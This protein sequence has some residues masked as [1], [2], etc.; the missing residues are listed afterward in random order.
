MSRVLVIPDLGKFEIFENGDVWRTCNGSHKYKLTSFIGK[1]GYHNFYIRVKNKRKHV[2]LHRLIAMAFIPNPNNLP[3]VRHLDGNKLNN[4]LDNLAW[5][6]H[7]DNMSD[8]NWHHNRGENCGASK[9]TWKIVR[10]IRELFKRSTPLT[11]I[12]LA[13]YFGVSQPTISDIR[14]GAT[15]HAC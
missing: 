13:E 3:E 10:A 4:N 7:N 5:G 1:R 14:R 8:E 15:W 12:R 2:Y 11:N 6:T 9:L